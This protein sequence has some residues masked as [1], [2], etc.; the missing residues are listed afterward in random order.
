MK[1]LCLYY[2]SSMK[3]WHL[4]QG[5]NAL[6][7]VLLRVSFCYLIWTC[8]ITSYLNRSLCGS[9]YIVSDP[10]G[11]LKRLTEQFREEK[12][13][14]KRSNYSFLKCPKNYH[15]IQPLQVTCFKLRNTV[16]SFSTLVGQLREQSCH[17]TIVF[18]IPKCTISVID[19]FFCSASQFCLIWKKNT[20]LLH[21]YI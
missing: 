12:K 1:V 8:H 7:H 11:F 15:E 19:T 4:L 3:S 10:L 18:Q 5:N 16:V 13:A 6:S 21:W 17:I 2:V 9:Y 14:S 20:L